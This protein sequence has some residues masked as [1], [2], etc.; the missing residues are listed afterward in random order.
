MFYRSPC[1]VSGQ[2]VGVLGHVTKDKALASLQNC[3]L[4]EDLYEWS[5]W[6]VVFEPELGDLKDFIQK[7]GGLH[8]VTI[9]SE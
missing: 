2:K 4:L 5:Q 1:L 6:H 8:V 7:H 9:A 3:P